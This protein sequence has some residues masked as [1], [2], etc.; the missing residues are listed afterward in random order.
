MLVAMVPLLTMAQKRS[1]KGKGKE[2]AEKVVNQATYNFMVI[3]G[4]TMMPPNSSERSGGAVE[5][6]PASSNNRDKLK[7]TFDFGG[8]RNNENV[9]LSE[10]QYR[11][12]A[13]AVNG[14]AAYNWEFI[15][16]NIVDAREGRYYYYYMRKQK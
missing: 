7:I 9:I 11:S 4:M 13:H 10:T 3:K 5:T 16:A 12:M 1:K 14:A 6:R 2:K 8:I 15:N